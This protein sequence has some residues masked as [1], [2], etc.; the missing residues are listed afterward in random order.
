MEPYGLVTRDA[1]VALNEFSAAFDRALI[2][3]APDQWA[4]ELG[5]THV[6]NSIRST[7]PI[8]LSSARFREAL[9]DDQYRRLYERSLSIKPKDYQDGVEELVRVIEAP[10]FVGWASHLLRWV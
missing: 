1:Q 8:P 4:T 5:F 3:A 10:D 9:G 7:F 6:S 2:V